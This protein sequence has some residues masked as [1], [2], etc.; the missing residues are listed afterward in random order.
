[1][2]SLVLLTSVF[3]I[4]EGNEDP[5]LLL[6]RMEGQWIAQFTQVQESGEYLDVGTSES[7]FRIKLGG[8]LIEEDTIV[9][10]AQNNFPIHV[11]YAYD[12]ARGVI[13]KSST[14]QVSGNMDIQEGVIDGGK[15]H[16]TNTKYGT[17]FVTPSGAELGFSIVLDFVDKDQMVMTAQLS[18]D[19]G[20]TWND[21]QIVHYRRVREI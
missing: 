9:R 13:R 10:T 19:H 15:L 11:Q 3:L 7:Q 8:K 2:L 14:D 4:G 21:F 16:L 17:W 1:M 6:K 18:F 20:E 12:A 5:L